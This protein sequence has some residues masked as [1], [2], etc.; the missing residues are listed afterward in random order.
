[1]F[2][3]SDDRAAGEYAFGQ[4]L[5]VFVVTVDFNEFDALNKFTGNGGF[6]DLSA[7][8]DDYDAGAGELGEDGPGS[9]ELLG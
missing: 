5:V 9:S 8:H 2:C 4:S 7:I 3:G 6:G 1:V